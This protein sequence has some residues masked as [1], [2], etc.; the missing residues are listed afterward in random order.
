MPFNLEGLISYETIMQEELPSVDWLVTKL[1]ANGDRVVLYGEP[2]AMKTWLLLHLAMH[3]AAGQSWLG[4]FE[5]PQPKAVLYIDEEMNQRMLRRRIK[6]LRI[7]TKAQVETSPQVLPF[8]VVSQPG[9]RFDGD[10]AQLLLQ[11]LKNS[12]FDPDV[13]IVES[14]RRVLVGSENEAQAIAEFWRNVEPIRQAGKTLIISHHMRKPSPHGVNQSRYRAS[15]STDV[16]AGADT[17][18]AIKR[19]TDRLLEVKCDKSRN[20]E[21]EQGFGV[22]FEDK[23]TDSPVEMRFDGYRAHT[24]MSTTE[25][26]RATTLIIEFFNSACERIADQREMKT[27]VMAQGISERTYQRAW[28]Q[29]RQSDRVTK[30]RRRKWQLVEQNVEA[31]LAAI[32]H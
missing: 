12:D 4:Q 20:A 5:I 27:H 15:G 25:E 32:K 22:K 3:I 28:G 9:L 18:F 31:E 30:K 21:E 23:N 17:A 26:A 10:G 29:V 11:A 2:G 1:I 6:R 13:V 14:L 8:R 19:V 24:G 7:N 16:L